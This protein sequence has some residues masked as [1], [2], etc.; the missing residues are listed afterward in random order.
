MAE[1]SSSM[2]VSNTG[3]ACDKLK[4]TSDSKERPVAA[5]E[6][7][8]PQP[9]ASSLT[10]GLIRPATKSVSADGTGSGVKEL[11]KTCLHRLS[12]Q[13]ASFG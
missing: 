6:T 4:D 12:L 8:K 9:R 10:A 5:A 11:F 13:D 1:S 3:F 2:P 7:S